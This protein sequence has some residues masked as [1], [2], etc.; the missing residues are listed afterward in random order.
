[1][2][3]NKLAV[4]ALGMAV[5]G[6]T[7]D[8]GIQLFA[9]S[10][11]TEAAVAP[12]AELISVNLPLRQTPVESLVNRLIE[13]QEPVKETE[14]A[15]V[16][17]EVQA[18]N[19]A[20]QEKEEQEAIDKVEKENAV[21]EAARKA[22]AGREAGAKAAAEAKAK[23]EAAAA[24]AAR[25]KEL[26]ADAT[27]SYYKGVKLMYSEP[28]EGIKNHITRSNGVVHYNGNR[29]TWYSIHE[30]GQTVTAVKIPG[31]HIAKDGTIRDVEGYIC[32]A[33]SQRYMRLYSTLMTSI[34]PAKVYDTGCSYG[35]IDIYTNW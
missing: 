7:L 11:I 28:Y 20:A 9:D 6:V 2:K 16:T 4:L 22:A 33:A 25:E 15:L 34:G 27:G 1:M 23:A 35:T 12:H 8:P 3:M 32:V 30:P 18:A 14:V 29:E 21:R 26:E 10:M 5:A 19:R 13:E 17:K 31:K 24:K